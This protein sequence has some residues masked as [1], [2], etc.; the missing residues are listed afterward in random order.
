MGKEDEDYQQ[1]QSVSGMEVEGR[2]YILRL[3]FVSHIINNV[4]LKCAYTKAIIPIFGFWC[5][6]QIKC[7][8]D[9]ICDGIRTLHIE[10]SSFLNTRPVKL[11]P[12]YFL[13]NQFA[14]YNCFYA[15]LSFGDLGTNGFD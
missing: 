4:F 7:H 2:T 9:V 12:A 11:V 5:Q 10:N 14:V 13:L 6:E 1:S 15:I 8:Q 3:H